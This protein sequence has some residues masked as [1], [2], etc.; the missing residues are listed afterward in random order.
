MQPSTPEVLTTD[1]CIVG[2]GP[3]GLMLGYLLARAG[4]QV[5]VIEKHSDF[6]RDFRGDT[7]HPST[8]EIMHHL[9]LLEELLRLPHQQLS[10]LQAE[11]AGEEIT[12]ADFSLL[13]VKC[14]FMAFMPQWD[15]LNFLSARASAMPNFT[16][17]QSTA[18][19]D[20]IYDGDTVCGVRAM[21]AGSPCEIRARLVAGCDGRHSMVRQLA[22]LTGQSFGSPRDVLWFQLNKCA[23]D[24]AWNTGHKGPKQNFIMLDRG[25]FWQC[26]YTI[27]KGQ[28]AAIKEAGIDCF[29]QQVA[30]VAPFPLARLQPLTEWQQFRLLDIRIDRLDNWM[31][32]GVLCIGDAAH[33][34]SPIGGVGV[35]LAIQDAVASANYLAA[36]LRKGDV[37]LRL[38]KKVQQ[39]RQFPTRA[40]QF[41]QIKMSGK[42]RNDDQPS[43]LPRIIKRFPFLP[44]IFGWIIG[45][46]FRREK[47]RRIITGR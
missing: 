37:S 11:I 38:L 36:A 23:D 1:C 25:S 18:L 24:P 43:P 46:G 27:D 26:G 16:L 17:R 9:G 21:S 3:A 6:L 5:I 34:M 45:L 31:K 19:S 2:G 35:N 28:Y 7:I 8:L 47:P 33:A 12:L 10:R 15:F 4:V 39:R 22:G 42:K 41:I 32:P 40:T 20:L 13:P 29:K 14:R 44:W 30:A